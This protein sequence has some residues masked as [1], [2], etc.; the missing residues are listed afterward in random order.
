MDGEPAIRGI[1]SVKRRC[2]DRGLLI[3]FTLGQ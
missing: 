1:T 3:V 2:T